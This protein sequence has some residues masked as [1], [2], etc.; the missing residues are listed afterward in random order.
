MF[1]DELMETDVAPKDI[2]SFK[3]DTQGTYVDTITEIC[4]LHGSDELKRILFELREFAKKPRTSAEMIGNVE[5]DPEY[6][7]IVQA[8]LLAV[9]IDNEIVLIHRFVKDKYKK[10]FPELDSMILGELDF[11]QT[12]RELG[13]D[14]DQVKNNEKLQQTL[15]QATIMIVSVTASTTQG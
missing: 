7:L 13:N 8:N 15:T 14:L 2:F 9:E 5:S 6:Q 3:V 10:R 11:I 12:V 1:Q 4:K